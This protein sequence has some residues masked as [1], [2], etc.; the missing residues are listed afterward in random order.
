[1]NSNVKS[2]N[3]DCQILYIGNSHETFRGVNDALGISRFKR[4]VGAGPGL[5]REAGENLQ[6]AGHALRP[7]RGGRKAKAV[8]G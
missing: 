2:E 6:H 3:N 4:D 5:G 8:Q 1:M 7:C